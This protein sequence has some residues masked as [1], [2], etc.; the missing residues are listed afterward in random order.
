MPWFSIDVKIY[1]TAYIY[2]KTAAEALGEAK[3]LSRESFNTMAN[4]LVYDGA[5]DAGA[6]ASHLSP[7]MT[8]YGPDKGD[9][10]A[11]VD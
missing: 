7:M 8:L 5:L 1:A 9:T 2:A 6:P 4:D 11:E 10:P 3:A